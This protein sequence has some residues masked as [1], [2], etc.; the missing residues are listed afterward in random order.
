M[1]TRSNL[2]IAAA[3]L[4]VSGAASFAPGAGAADA[5]TQDGPP[6]TSHG[7]CDQ[8]AGDPAAGTPEWMQ[9][10]AHNVDCSYQRLE[11]AQSN[12]AYLAKVAEQQKVE[13]EEFATVTAPAW[14]A[15]PNRRRAAGGTA[16]QSKVGDP[17]RSPEEWAAA[18]RGRHLKFSFI[19]RDG[20]KLAARLY[21]PLDESKTYPAVTFTPGLQSFNEVNSWFPQGLAEAGYVVLIIDPQNQGDSEACGH[22]P[23]G[24]ETTCP[25]TNQPNDT[26]S[27]IDFILST[28]ES[29]Y[30]WALGLNAAGTPTYN[31][32]WQNVDRAHLGIAGH[33]LGAIAVTPI[34]QQDERVDA[35]I[36]YDNLDGTLP[37]AG[38]RR[39]P[40]LFFYTDY[41]FPAT[42]TPKSS[43]PNATQHF[44]AF[45]QLSSA[46][47]DVMSM[48]TRASDHYEWGYQPYPANFPASRYGER[49]AFFYSLAWFDRY[50]K[51]DAAG[52]ARLTAYAFDDSSDRH[53]IGT[54]TYDV[55]RA[56]ANP[57]NPFAGNVPYTIGGKCVANLLSIYYASAFHLEGGSVSSTEMRSRGC[58]IPVSIDVKPGMD[59]ATNPITVTAN[60]TVP[61]A[62]LWTP[63]Y[64][65]VTQTDRSSLT[66]GKTG[67]ERSLVQCGVEDVN[68]DGHDD[69]VCTF[70]NRKLGYTGAEGTTTAHLRGRTS[71]PGPVEIRGQD[72]VRV[73]AI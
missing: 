51:G 25:T 21:A 43:P 27:A 59:N 68:A 54:G 48:T 11:D 22:A 35:A 40:T 20:A 14:A 12:P 32:W 4:I 31:P 71:G 18:G 55:Q 44:G 73:K 58:R 39:T 3:V 38:P 70:D 62:I 49:V 36:S 45:N 50:L 6:N 61:V 67:A 56:A 7:V 23:D 46:G 72:T 47:V 52:T 5:P 2:A 26:R 60:G 64:D 9:R 37:A 33:S 24:T 28:P 42:G 1:R 17:F 16:P 10:D 53:S 41:A 29:P 63:S 57:T 69:L 30:P 66:F 34:A 65:P 13:A 8:Y 19:N 15:E